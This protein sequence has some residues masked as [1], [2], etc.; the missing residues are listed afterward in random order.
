MY[1]YV[2]VYIYMYIY[3]YIHIYIYVYVYIYVLKN[4]QHA[5]FFVL[6]YVK[7]KILLKVL[8]L[9]QSKNGVFSS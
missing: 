3:M 9:Q 7:S 4:F 5:I 6:F 1:V 8:K 2:Y